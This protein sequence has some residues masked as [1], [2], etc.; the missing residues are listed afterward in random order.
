MDNETAATL[1][2]K[3]DNTK[4][5]HIIAAHLSAKNN[6]PELARAALS[7]ALDCTVDWIGIAEQV[8]GFNWRNF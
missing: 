5:K 7:R 3:L 1:L 6:T 2:A 8:N 4:L